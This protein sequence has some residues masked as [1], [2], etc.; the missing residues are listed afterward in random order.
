MKK[1]IKYLLILFTL[2]GAINSSAQMVLMDELNESKKKRS[3]Y[4][5]E[6]SFSQ[7][8]KELKKAA[9]KGRNYTLE[10]CAK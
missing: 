8:I 10:N 7:F 3:E 9:N 4:K 5:Q 6:M 1:T 2:S